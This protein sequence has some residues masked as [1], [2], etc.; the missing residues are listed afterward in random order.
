MLELLSHGE[1]NEDFARDVRLGE[2]GKRCGSC[3]HPGTARRKKWVSG[4]SCTRVWKAGQPS[5][6]ILPG[7][8][9]A[10]EFLEPV[11]DQDHFGD[12]LGLPL[13][14]LDHEKSLPIEGQIIGAHGPTE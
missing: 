10:L 9:E 12:R 1:A 2:P 3:G 5:R 8:G 6:L 11:L 4:I 14:Q 13:F 7:G